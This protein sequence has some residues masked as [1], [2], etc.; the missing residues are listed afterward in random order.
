[1]QMGPNDAPCSRSQYFHKV[2]SNILILN[3]LRSYEYLNWEVFLPNIGFGWEPRALAP[4]LISLLLE[5]EIGGG[6]VIGKTIDAMLGN[7]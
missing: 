4:D 3:I 1:M 6:N 7:M 2:L 5:V